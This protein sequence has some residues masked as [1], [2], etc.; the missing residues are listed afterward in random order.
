MLI[1]QKRITWLLLSV[2]ASSISL[3]VATRYSRGETA[4]QPSQPI[5][6]KVLRK[7]DEV[8]LKPTKEEIAH[9]QEENETNERRLENTIPKHV[10]L[11]IRIRKEKEAAFKDLA[12]EKWARDFEIEITNS[13]NKPIYEFYLLLVLPGVRTRG[14]LKVVFPL[15]FGSYELADTSIRAIAEDVP[16]WPGE[17]KV[18]KIDPRQVPVW[19]KL[20][21]EDHRPQP[22][23]VQLKLEGLSFGDGTGYVGNE[24]IA[25]PRAKVSGY[26]R[27]T[28]SED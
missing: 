24:G 6:M 26:S 9:S 27:L 23:K 21:R 28:G 13:A 20:Q 15:V 25:I 1:T 22:N 4:F 18:F 16:I 19:E 7:K 11:K 12:N 5:R 10:P 3:I 8:G 2:L 14:G 17:T